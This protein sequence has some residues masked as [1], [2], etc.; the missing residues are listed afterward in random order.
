MAGRAVVGCVPPKVAAVG[1]AGARPPVGPPAP[2]F[3][4]WCRRRRRRRRRRWWRRRHRRAA[5]LEA[6]CA[7]VVRPRLEPARPWAVPAGARVLRGPIAAALVRE[8]RR[9][10]RPRRCRRRRWAGRRREAAVR[11][12]LGAVVPRISARRARHVGRRA[13]VGCGPAAVACV[14]SR[15]RRGCG[16]DRKGHTDQARCAAAGD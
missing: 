13:G 12:A 16:E 3:V 8:P 6:L 15:E 10:G 11:V 14:T 7:V 4:R 2:A 5:V 9:E 1:C